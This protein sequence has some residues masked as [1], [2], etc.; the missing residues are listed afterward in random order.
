MD[1][2]PVEITITRPALFKREYHFLKGTELVG[3]INIARSVRL[4]TIAKFGAEE[5][6]ISQDGWWRPFFRYEG[7][8]RPYTKDKFKPHWNGRVDI[9]MPDGSVYTLKKVKWYH[10]ARVWFKGDEPVLRLNPFYAFNKKRAGI[11]LY[12]PKDPKIWLLVSI[13][14]HLHLINKR[15][16]TAAS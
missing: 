14:W 6:K 5:W 12:L 15:Q 11:T 13:A 4:E 9:S 1:K 8:H 3:T 2:N 16:A 7:S 10:A